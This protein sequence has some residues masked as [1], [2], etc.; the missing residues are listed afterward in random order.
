[1]EKTWS[2][3]NP[4]QTPFKYQSFFL[5]KQ[6]F[7]IL[8]LG[9]ARMDEEDMRGPQTWGQQEDRNP[10]YGSMVRL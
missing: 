10:Y 1:M 4:V 9:F 7:N 8:Y 3:E 2:S 6:I 5:N